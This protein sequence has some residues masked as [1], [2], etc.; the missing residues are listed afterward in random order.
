MKKINFKFFSLFMFLLTNFAYASLD[1]KVLNTGRS[2]MKIGE[3]I[4]L[5]GMVIAGIAFAVGSESA[6]RLASQ[7]F[8]GFLLISTSPSIIQWLKRTLGN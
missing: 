3:S 5:V 1:Q 4:G 7:A 8:V 6:R 2:L